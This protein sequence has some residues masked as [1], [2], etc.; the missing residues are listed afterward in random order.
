MVLGLDLGKVSMTGIY[1]VTDL[2][3]GNIKHKTIQFFE[4]ICSTA[5][6]LRKSPSKVLQ[7]QGYVSNKNTLIQYSQI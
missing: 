2:K 7:K 5:Q 6:I 3:M 1:D 4:D